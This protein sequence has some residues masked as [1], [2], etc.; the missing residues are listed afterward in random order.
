MPASATSAW[1]ASRH[2]P[3]AASTT[4]GSCPSRSPIRS[5]SN[6]AGTTCRP[7]KRPSN[8]PSWAWPKVP[9]IR[10]RTWCRKRRWMPPRKTRLAK[11]PSTHPPLAPPRRPG[12][13][14]TPTLIC[15]APRP[16]TSSSPPPWSATCASP[17]SAPT[18][19]RTTSC[20]TS[21]PCP[22]RCW[23]ARASASSRP[24]WMSEASRTAR[25]S[26]ASPARA[27]ASGRATT[28]SA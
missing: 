17:K 19:T 13:P 18:T 24:A 26:T 23:K 6:S 5:M 11:R 27:T 1:I 10:Q 14:R 7:R 2:A 9:P 15:T 4:G 8:W 22:F 12:R 16:P 28:T 3:P 20:W 21:G 25:A